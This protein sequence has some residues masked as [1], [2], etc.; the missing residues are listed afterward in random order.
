M[1]HK[2]SGQSE[3]RNNKREVR[4][5]MN[6][7]IVGK[8][9]EW[10]QHWALEAKSPL[11]GSG[12]GRRG[13]VWDRKVPSSIIQDPRDRTS[14]SLAERIQ[15]RSHL[16]LFAKSLSLSFALTR[17]LVQLTQIDDE[18]KFTSSGITSNYA[19]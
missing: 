2:E 18:G 9:P 13:E 8:C 12:G 10:H 15:R 6:A 11:S 5:C 16:Q 3:K 4:V 7:Q 14:H 17:S 19:Y 1:E